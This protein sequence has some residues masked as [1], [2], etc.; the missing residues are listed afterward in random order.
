[1]SPLGGG[2][3]EKI[4]KNIFSLGQWGF[5]AW[6]ATRYVCSEVG[7]QAST[8]VV[9]YYWSIEYNAI[10]LIVSARDISVGFDLKPTVIMLIDVS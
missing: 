4:Y 7:V 2:D 5:T 9:G 3:N 10:A 8:Y 1:M 6:C